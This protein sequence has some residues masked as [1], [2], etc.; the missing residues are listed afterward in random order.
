MSVQKKLLDNG[1]SLSEVLHTSQDNLHEIMQ[2]FRTSTIEQ[3]RLLF[4]VFDRLASLQAWAVGEISWLDTIV[5]YIS[6]IIISYFIT[7]TP[8]THEA[9]IWIFI[10]VTVNAI[11]ERS[12]VTYLLQDN[13]DHIDLVNDNLNWWIWMC[14]KLMVTVCVLW[15]GIA[16][17]TYLDYNVVNHELLLTI[18][19]QNMEVINYFEKWRSSVSLNFN[20]TSKLENSVALNE[21][22][23]SLEENHALKNGKMPTSTYVERYSPAMYPSNKLPST[24]NVQTPNGSEGSH[25]FSLP[26]MKIIEELISPPSRP[27]S[28][29]SI[30]ST[31]SRIEMTP[32]LALKT[33]YSTSK[34]SLRCLT[35]TSSAEDR[36]DV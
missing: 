3:K 25:V 28:R 12:I 31:R 36:M 23:N 27:S 24:D 34:Y 7:A 17:Y 6:C 33:R 22:V 26:N 18:Q 14:R 32:D 10:T 21:N 4:E 29:S 9:R 20:G 35:P 11:L 1:I 15:I 5:F 13:A 8:R 2:E 30:R 16:F 19:K